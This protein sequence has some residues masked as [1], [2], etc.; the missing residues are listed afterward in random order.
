MFRLSQGHSV[1]VNAL[2]LLV[3]P[4]CCVRTG[5]HGMP[6]AP[7]SPSHVKSGRA[8]DGMLPG[9]IKHYQH[10]ALQCI[11][12]IMSALQRRH[13]L[14][15]AS[16]LPRILRPSSTMKPAMIALV[17]AMACMMFP[18]MPYSQEP[19]HLETLVSSVDAHELSNV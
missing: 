9:G 19:N 6:A 1:A 5:I 17:V 12:R 15:D 18:A 13:T 3:K 2:P 4:G 7:V 16:A 11:T 10:L 8:K 14:Q